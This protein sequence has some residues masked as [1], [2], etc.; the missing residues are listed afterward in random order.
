MLNNSC[1]GL[2]SQPLEEVKFFLHFVALCSS[3]ID[4]ETLSSRFVEPCPVES[5]ANTSNVFPRL[6]SE[7]LGTFRSAV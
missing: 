2:I 7:K 6:L 5:T 3:F 4:L 1:S